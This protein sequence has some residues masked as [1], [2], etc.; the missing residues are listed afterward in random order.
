MGLLHW[1]LLF[2]IVGSGWYGE[3]TRVNAFISPMLPFAA[4][5]GGY[6]RPP[7]D[8]TVRAMSGVVLPSTTGD[9]GVSKD[10]MTKRMPAHHHQMTNAPY[11]YTTGRR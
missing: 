11:P 6:S 10:D 2:I 9:E 1:L 4:P 5:G 8:L 7:H 3:E